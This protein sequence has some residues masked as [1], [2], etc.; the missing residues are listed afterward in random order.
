MDLLGEAL[1]ELGLF[2]FGCLSLPFDS[3][4]SF[5]SVLDFIVVIFEFLLVELAGTTL[6]GLV[7][8]PMGAHLGMNAR[9]ASGTTWESVKHRFMITSTRQKPCST[10]MVGVWT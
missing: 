9:R 5:D 7:L 10:L 1:G 3:F 4:D 6:L 2:V 8:E